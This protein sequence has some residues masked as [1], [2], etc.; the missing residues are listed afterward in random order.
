MRKFIADY[1]T[2]QNKVLTKRA[3]DNKNPKPKTFVGPIFARK[4][5]FKSIVNRADTQNLKIK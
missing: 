2:K 1:R 5:Y 4:K 3:K